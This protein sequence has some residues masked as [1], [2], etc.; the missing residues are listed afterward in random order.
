MRKILQWH[1]YQAVCLTI[2]C[3]LCGIKNIAAQDDLMAILDSG[4][5]KESGAVTGAF[6]S[7]RVING[8]SIEFIGRNVL[9]VR[10]LHRFGVIKDGISE[11]FGLDQA[12]MRLG[13]DYGVTKNL[14]IGAGRSTLAKELDGFIKYRALQQATGKTNIPLS[15]VLVAGSTVT[16]AKFPADAVFTKQRHRMAYYSQV[17]IGRK[18]SEA[19]SLQLSPTYVH[20]NVVPSPAD[21]N[22]TYAVGLGSRIKLSKR[23]AF[24]ADYH[25][26]ISGLDKDAYSNPLSIGFDI[27]T[28]GHVFQLH[29]SN[30]TGMNEK[31]FITNTS[32]SWGR[33]EIRFGFNLSR[34]FTV[35]KKK[36]LPDPAI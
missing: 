5:H 28:G 32:N 26:V 11:L 7:S 29:F 23:V 4:I 35:G 25:Y 9:D 31:A 2:V 18:F 6:K 19:F 21:F 3:A 13:F 15:V 36:A 34:V 24:V 20:R 30:A 12:S 16:T 27:E 10:I 8:H 17:I 1:Q 22:D 33:G 14:T